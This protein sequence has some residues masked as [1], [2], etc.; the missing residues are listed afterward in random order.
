MG[1]LLLS[2]SV[3]LFYLVTCRVRVWER[4]R[5]SKSI[6]WYQSRVKTGQDMFESSQVKSSQVMEMEM[7]M[8]EIM[9]AVEYFIFYQCHE[10]YHLPMYWMNGCCVSWG[11]KANNRWRF[12]ST[13]KFNSQ[14]VMLTLPR[15]W[16][17]FPTLLSCSCSLAL[18]R[19][20]V[21]YLVDLIYLVHP[22]LTKGGGSR[23]RRESIRSLS[24]V[25][26]IFIGIIWLTPSHPFCCPEH[27]WWS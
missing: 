1:V 27:G 4:E 23:P 14:F 10:S 21:V 19:P 2:Y 8:M 3:T 22:E 5:E 17:V 20:Y 11:R 16:I 24:I 15:P 12:L 7:E 26:I 25:I 13:T 18:L 9:S 6:T